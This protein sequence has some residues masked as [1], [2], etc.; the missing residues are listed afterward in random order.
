MQVSKVSYAKSNNSIDTLVITT[1][2]QAMASALMQDDIVDNS[3]MRRG[4][5]CWFRLPKV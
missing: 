5:P 4:K 1:M 2:F 3:N